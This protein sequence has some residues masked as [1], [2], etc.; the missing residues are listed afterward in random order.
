MTLL[1]SQSF[2]LDLNF[3]TISLLVLYPTDKLFKKL[4]LET[5]LWWE[6]KDKNFVLNNVEDFKPLINKVSIRRFSHY[7][8]KPIILKQLSKS[9]LMEVNKDLDRETIL[10]QKYLKKFNT[11]YKYYFLMNEN[12]TNRLLTNKEINSR[13]IESLFILSGI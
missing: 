11:L 3:L 9:E 8:L 4:N 7:L 2:H 13:A 5:D 1:D 12:N 6:V 10:L